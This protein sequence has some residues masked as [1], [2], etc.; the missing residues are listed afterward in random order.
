M[1]REPD[2]KEMRGWVLFDD[3]CGVCRKWV[4]FWE[5]TLRAQGLGIAALQAEWVVERLGTSDEDRLMD[6]RILFAD[7]TQLR[8]ADAYRHVLRRIW[9]A[10]PLYLF[11]IAP[12]TGRIFDAC[13]RRFAN[14]RH[15]ISRACRLPPR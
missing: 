13:Y 10:F 14:H 7:G 5:R 9:W 15:R 4:P 3:S 11:S 6:L 12:L 8:G 2:V 1:S